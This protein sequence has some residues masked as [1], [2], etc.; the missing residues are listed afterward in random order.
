MTVG[1]VVVVELILE[2]ERESQRIVVVDCRRPG[3]QLVHASQRTFLLLHWGCRVSAEDQR[4]AA[5]EAVQRTCAS[6][7]FSF[8]F[9]PLCV[10][11]CVCVYPDELLLT[12]A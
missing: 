6:G 4:A 5:G 8:L 9:S 12:R 11:V 7:L 1:V 3:N 2:R 10:C